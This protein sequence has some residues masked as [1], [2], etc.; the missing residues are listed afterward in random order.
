MID[1]SVTGR[2]S[3][4]SLLRESI[5]HKFILDDLMNDQLKATLMADMVNFSAGA[6]TFTQFEVDGKVD[7]Y[8]QRLLPWLNDDTSLWVSEDSKAQDLL[9]KFQTN[10]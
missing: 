8:T 9:K 3:G 5:I 7:K 10:G 2:E 4:E 6:G 1:Y